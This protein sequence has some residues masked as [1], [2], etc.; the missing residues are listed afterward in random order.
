MSSWSNFKAIEAICRSHNLGN[1]ANVHILNDIIATVEQKTQQ[2]SVSYYNITYSKILLWNSSLS[3]YCVYKLINVLS[4]HDIRDFLLETGH[5]YK[6]LSHINNK[7]MNA[8][9]SSDNETI[10]RLLVNL[11]CYNDLYDKKTLK[12]FYKHYNIKPIICSKDELLTTLAVDRCNEI[13]SGYFKGISDFNLKRA[14]RKFP[15]A[16]IALQHGVSLEVISENE[17]SLA[18]V[19]STTSFNDDQF[20]F[21]LNN[22]T[23]ESFVRL[24]ENENLTEWQINALIDINEASV[25]VALSNNYTLSYEH[26]QELFDRGDETWGGLYNNN[27]S[28]L[29]V[30]MVYIIEEYWN[31][32]GGYAPW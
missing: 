12:R 30:N 9:I 1:P 8:L 27:G 22:L 11:I 23:N 28:K 3:S 15:L 21:L 5:V 13:A 24:A 31:S 20:Q 19:I 10:N 6:P 29:T 7:L 14:Y 17:H 2:N 26:V 32:L 16:K 18:S 4:E 25:D